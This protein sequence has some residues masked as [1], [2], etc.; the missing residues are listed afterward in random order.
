MNAA[1]TTH[2]SHFLSPV[3]GGLWELAVDQKASNNGMSQRGELAVR[4]VKSRK[5]QE[6][7]GLLGWIDV[8]AVHICRA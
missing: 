5:A 4:S 2:P 6:V 1:V 3:Q 7:P 8:K